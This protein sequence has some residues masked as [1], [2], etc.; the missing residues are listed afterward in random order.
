MSSTTQKRDYFEMVITY[1]KKVKD[2][3]SSGVGEG[4]VKEI[5]GDIWEQQ[6]E[7]KVVF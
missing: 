5:T 4:V 3:Q 2:H 7:W 1:L 6:T